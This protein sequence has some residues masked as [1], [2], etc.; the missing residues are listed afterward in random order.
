[1]GFT[2]N[3][4]QATILQE[5]P[6]ARIA[7]VWSGEDRLGYR[8]RVWCGRVVVCEA[9]RVWFDGFMAGE[10]ADFLCNVMR[11]QG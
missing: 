10:D 2:L 8:G 3:D 6:V 11:H 5:T 9:I 1:M 7:D 4:V